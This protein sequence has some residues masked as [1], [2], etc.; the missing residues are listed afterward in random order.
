MGIFAVPGL[1]KKRREKSGLHFARTPCCGQF[2]N[3]CWKIFCL[4]CAARNTR[5]EFHLLH[6]LASPGNT[7]SSNTTMATCLTPK[8]TSLSYSDRSPPATAKNIHGGVKYIILPILYRPIQY[9]CYYFRT[10]IRICEIS[11]S[12]AKRTIKICT[13]S[14]FLAKKWSNEDGFGPNL[15]Y[16]NYTIWMLITHPVFHCTTD[17]IFNHPR[18]KRYRNKQL[19]PKTNMFSIFETMLNVLRNPKGW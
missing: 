8:T 9:D 4:R 3:K 16:H 17:D 11:W 7:L 1:P 6:V 15:V 10:P 12:Q 5:G 18:H 19:N 14:D 13:P 2:G